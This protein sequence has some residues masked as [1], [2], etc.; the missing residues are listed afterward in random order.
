MTK[1][2]LTIGLNDKDTKKQ[3]LPTTT[4]HEIIK[5]ILQEYTDGYTIYNTDGGYKHDDGTFI[6]ESSIRVELLFTPEMVV[7]LV[8]NKIKQQLNQESIALETIE[9]NS[10]LI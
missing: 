3:E 7:L 2:I 1:H 9:T 10:K 4:I 8:A 6:N 5:T